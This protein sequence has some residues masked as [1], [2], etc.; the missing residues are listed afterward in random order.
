M[1]ARVPTPTA[2]ETG[3]KQTSQQGRPPTGWGGVIRDPSSTL[4]TI[5]SPAGSRT[6][7]DVLPE[8]PGAEAVWAA[9]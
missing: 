3:G 9:S 1:G 4:T 5:S 7:A 6:H 2:N 8:G